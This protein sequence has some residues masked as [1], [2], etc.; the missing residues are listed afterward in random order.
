MVAGAEQPSEAVAA[1]EDAAGRNAG[2]RP[3]ARRSVARGRVAGRDPD[4][5]L[6]ARG[7]ARALR[8]PHLLRGISAHRPG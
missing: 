2:R 5:A 1:Q 3:Q 8:M 4:L 7:D 6:V